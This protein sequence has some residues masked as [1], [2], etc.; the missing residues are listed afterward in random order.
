M[1]WII[2]WVVWLLVALILSGSIAF[3]S[4]PDPPPV[5]WVTPDPPPV[6]V[7]PAA[8]LPAQ[9]VSVSEWHVPA[10]DEV[11]MPGNHWHY[12]PVT[13]LY[14][15]HS[16]AYYGNVRAHTAPSGNVVWSRSSGPIRSLIRGR[17][18]CP[19]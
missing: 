15:Q 12:D 17:S 7:P 6:R 8:K 18:N 16:D 14:K 13:G 11:L 2:Q 9:A 5:R 10:L 4:T 1:R 19:K 3:A